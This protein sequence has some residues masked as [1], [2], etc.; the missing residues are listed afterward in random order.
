MKKGLL[1]ELFGGSVQVKILETLLIGENLDI[2]I[3][4]LAEEASTSNSRAYEVVEELKKKG[5]L[6]PSR[7]V[8]N[9]QLYKLNYRN[10]IVK[11]LDRLYKNIIQTS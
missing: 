10:K 8:G 11:T 9:K 7:K 2:S 3:T 5:Y 4:T 1:E 6:V